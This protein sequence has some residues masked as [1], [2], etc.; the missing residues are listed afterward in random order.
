MLE[1]P[2][3]ATAVELAIDG[4]AFGAIEGLLL[5]VVRFDGASAFR[6][7]DY[8]QP[9]YL[10]DTFRSTERTDLYSAFVNGIYKLSPYFSSVISKRANEGFYTVSDVAPDDFFSTTYFGLY[11]ETKRVSDEGLFFLKAGNHGIV[12][13]IERKM[14][15]SK[16]SEN[17]L[18]ALRD[19]L[20][21]VKSL[22]RKELSF[23][24]EAGERAQPAPAPAAIRLGLSKREQEVAELLLQGH[25]SKSAARVLGISPHT[26]R[27]HRKRLYK[28]LGINSHME[29]FRLFSR[30]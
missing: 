5:N 11:Y 2:A 22:L 15:S 19:V 4:N 13:M 20:P 30:T 3:I 16:F 6:F 10:Y 14:P 25:S 9:V 12:F 26:E 8:E 29:L 18:M 28:R 24:A 7:D 27:V 17:E 23:R 1:L 21:I